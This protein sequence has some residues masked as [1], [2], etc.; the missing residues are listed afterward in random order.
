MRT[1]V[2]TSGDELA[3]RFTAALESALLAQALAET[4]TLP[5]ERTKALL[6]DWV[7]G[8]FNAS[9][10]ALHSIPEGR[11]QLA[12][13]PDGAG[14]RLTWHAPT[15]MACPLAR[16]YEQPGGTWVALIVA[17]VR[18]DLIEA[19]AAAEW[20]VSRLTSP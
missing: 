14:F 1:F 5:D 9:A 15:G 8:V 10:V 4:G 2:D 17:G 11:G 20:G 18:D 7:A 6:R 12:W 13:E 19:M 16:I 3:A